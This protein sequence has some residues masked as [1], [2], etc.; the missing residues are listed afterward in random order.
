MCGIEASNLEPNDVLEQIGKKLFDALS[1]GKV[2]AAIEMGRSFARRS[3]VEF[4]LRL[5][6]DD[7]LSPI[8]SISM[9]V[10]S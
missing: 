10:N 1:A 2:G 5:R 4:H 7:K 8:G 6:F 9:G 3:S